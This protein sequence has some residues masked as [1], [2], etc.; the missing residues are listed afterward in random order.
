MARGAR[1]ERG[2]GYC[3]RYFTKSSLGSFQHI[4]IPKP[5]DSISFLTQPVI[6]SAVTYIIRM[7]TS[8]DFD[9]K[10]LIEADEVNDVRAYRCLAFKFQVKKAVGAQMIP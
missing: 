9:N 8:I 10:L 6:T 3:A 2:I 4:V 1:R 7:L 5:E